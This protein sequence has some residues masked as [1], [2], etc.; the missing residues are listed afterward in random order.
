MFGA[1][2][3]AVALHT[4]LRLLSG[5]VRAAPPGSLGAPCRPPEE[6][7][8]RIADGTGGDLRVRFALRGSQVRSRWARQVCLRGMLPP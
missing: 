1:S 7:P 4:S 6:T 2:A 5:P 3:A 8:Q